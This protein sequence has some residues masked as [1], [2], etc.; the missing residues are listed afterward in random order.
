M[1]RMTLA[2]VFCLTLALSGCGYHLMGMGRGVVPD[3]VQTV[4]VIGVGNVSP[5]FLRA[6]KNYVRDHASGYSISS[7]SNQKADVQMRIGNLHETLIPITF[8]AR[9]IATV[10]RMTLNGDLSLWR[11]NKRIWSSGAVSAFED[12]DVSGGPTAIESAKARIRSD[13]DAAW[14][15]QAWL[16]LSSGF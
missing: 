2:S 4:R 1:K 15:R 9:G 13:L 16:K 3:D 7:D 10:D 12:V 14:M 11:D 8:D 6:W 5:V